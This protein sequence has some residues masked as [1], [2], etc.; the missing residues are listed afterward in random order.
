MS[1]PTLPSADP[2]PS[3][4][5]RS[6][7]EAQAS[8]VFDWELLGELPLVEK[9]PSAQAFDV[10]YQARTAA[11]LA[12]MGTRNAVSAVVEGLEA[13]R[14]PGGWGQALRRLEQ[15][16]RSHRPER[17][18]D[19]AELFTF[20]PAPEAT[21]RHAAED[22]YFGYQRLTGANPMLVRRVEALPAGM[23]LS[24]DRFSAA[25]GGLS[26]RGALG[27]G[28]VF[29][30]DYAVLDGL[31]AGPLPTGAREVWAPRCL[32]VAADGALMPVAIQ[33]GQGAHP[34]FTPADP[35]WAMAKI[36]VGSA[37][38]NYHEMGVHL[39]LMHFVV[40]G[41]AV[42]AKR[43]L[44]SNHPIRVLLEP[45][46]QFTLAINDAT[47]S[48]L[49]AP[50]A[51]AE[52]V[53][54][55]T[56]AGSITLA[57]RVID[58][59]DF[60]RGGHGDDLARRG[61]DDRDVLPD[62]PYRDDGALSWAAIE[63]F[64]GDYVALYYRDDAAV[65]LDP[66]LRAWLA[67][68]GAPRGGGVRGLGPVVDRAD[69]VRT[70]THLVFRATVQ[71]AAVNDPQLFFDGYVPNMPGAGYA[72][73]PTPGCDTSE[74]A[75]LAMLP[76]L[77]RALSQVNFMYWLTSFKVNRLGDYPDGHFTDPRVAPLIARFRTALD[78]AS[79]TIA[80]RNVRRRVAYPWMDPAEV[81]AS[82]HM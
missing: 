22:W 3:A 73:A 50:G 79:R 60:D 56:V 19:Y 21:I 34:V 1:T 7:A 78:V 4:R 43:Q 5:A 33:C 39:G 69:L 44:A 77:D 2:D 14:G 25:A 31:P 81:T 65:A 63:Q 66:E 30:C 40:E 27:A 23:A 17:L 32:L 9:V 18:S 16:L 61:L 75:L 70:V 53:L 64:V 41:L 8:H 28:R 11:T 62:H 74:A 6:L 55:P 59:L 37:D 13:L 45:H 58:Q 42:A 49:F 36:V 68:A 48:I 57:R 46:L 51:Y 54:A 80:E 35:E 76:P 15:D 52:K 71:H 82:I 24:E 10:E 72:P 26:L 12:N 38:L 47:R 29:L 20:A 67:E